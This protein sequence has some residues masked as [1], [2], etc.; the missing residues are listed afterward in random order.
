MKDHVILKGFP[1]KISE[2][3]ELPDIAELMIYPSFQDHDIEDVYRNGADFQRY[4]LDKVDLSNTK[5]RVCVTSQ[6]TLLTPTVRSLAPINGNTLGNEW[7]I[8]YEGEGQYIYNEEKDIVHMLTNDVTSCTQFLE[9]DVIVDISPNTEYSEFINYV[10]NNLEKLN[11]KPKNVKPNRIVTFTN[12]MYREASPLRPE[13]KFTFKVVE[14]DRERTAR[15]HSKS[16]ENCNQVSV[17]N[18]ER[19]QMMKNMVRETGKVI[20][21]LPSITPDVLWKYPNK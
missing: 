11:I 21:H 9:K 1:T 2:E 12:H 15:L 7:R 17:F 4:L 14:T 8:D 6:V 10:H 3:V 19:Q 18:I 16:D 13:F 20:I 5:K